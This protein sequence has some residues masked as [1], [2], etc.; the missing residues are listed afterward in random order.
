MLMVPA[1]FSASRRASRPVAEPTSNS[2]SVSAGSR[3]TAT[4]KVP[5]M[6][7]GYPT[8]A[9][10]GLIREALAIRKRTHFSADPSL[11]SRA[12][13][14][15]QKDALKWPAVRRMDRAA[16]I[17]AW[18]HDAA[19]QARLAG[20][21]QATPSPPVMVALIPLDLSLASRTRVCAR[22]DHK[23]S[24]HDRPPI[25]AAKRQS[26]RCHTARSPQACNGPPLGS[27]E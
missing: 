27:D 2:A 22:D 19:F 5:C 3:K 12:V 11:P 14:R 21:Y 13:F 20:R 24:S 7:I 26:Y 17:H 16:A 10:A 18:P 25:A 4:M 8:P 23:D 1:T 6:L 15:P 9:E